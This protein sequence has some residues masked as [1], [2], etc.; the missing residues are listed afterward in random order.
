[1]N[2]FNH[3]SFGAVAAWMNNYSLGIQRSP[4][5]TAFKEIIL[6]PTPD[7]DKK[8]TFAKGH[9]QSVYGKINSEWAINGKKWIFCKL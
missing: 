7:P 5:K 2:S 4:Q 8:M 6:K 9:Y 1:M 3:Y